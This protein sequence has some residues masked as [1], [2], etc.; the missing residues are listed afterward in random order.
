MS[1]IRK[2]DYGKGV[3]NKSTLVEKHISNSEKQ[4]RNNKR[5]C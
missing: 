3:I 4:S 1:Y 5:K 2:D